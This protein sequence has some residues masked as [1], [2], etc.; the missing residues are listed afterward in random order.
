[1]LLLHS[2]GSMHENSDPLAEQVVEWAPVTCRK[3]PADARG[4]RCVY[5]NECALPPS[6]WREDEKRPFAC[7][8]QSRDVPVAAALDS[9]GRSQVTMVTGSVNSSLVRSMTQGTLG[10]SSPSQCLCNLIRNRLPYVR[11]K[12]DSTGTTYIKIKCPDC[13]GEIMVIN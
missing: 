2:D 9:R 10:H 5:V 11:P 1:M 8:C 3:L 4:D 7:H 12:L 6:Y 13:Y